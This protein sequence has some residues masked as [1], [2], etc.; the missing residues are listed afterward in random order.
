MARR[1]LNQTR[2][3]KSTLIQ[4]WFNPSIPEENEALKAIDQIRLKHPELSNKAIIAYSVIYAAEKDGIE[5]QSP[6]SGT[7][8]MKSLKSIL[9]K[10][11]NL[12]SNGHM[13]R[14]DA[15]QFVGFAEQAGVKFEEL[16]ST[17]RSLARN[18]TG[19]DFEDED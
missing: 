13:T 14:Q 10:L 18:Y 16:D 15:A 1:K 11:D 8:I 5:V 4:A 3:D 6:V 19:F 17:T 2:R 7:Q 12:V 9:S